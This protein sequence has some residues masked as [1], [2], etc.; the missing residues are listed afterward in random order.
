MRRNSA[1]SRCPQRAFTLVEV[2]LVIAIAAVISAMA[3]PRYGESLA[4]Y[5]ASLAA[6]RVASDLALVQA[7]A[8][9]MGTTRSITFNSLQSS[10]SLTGETGLI[11]SQSTYSVTLGTDPYFATIVSINFGGASAISF[12]GYGVPSQGGTIVLRSGTAQRTVTLEAISGQTT[13]Q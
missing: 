8:R 3:M 13:I 10:Y 11:D 2:V 4:R 5:R 1:S 6:K 7:R 9:S 12:N